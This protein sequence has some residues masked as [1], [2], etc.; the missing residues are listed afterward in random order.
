ME[1]ECCELGSRLEKVLSLQLFSASMEAAA[2]AVRLRSLRDS[3][4]GWGL[5]TMSG[6]IKEGYALHE[7]RSPVTDPWRP[8]YANTDG[9]VFRLAIRLDTAH[10]NGRGMLHGGVIASLADNAMG[11]TLGLAMES[12]GQAELERDKAKGIVTTH[13]GVD[14]IGI[15]ELGQWVEVEPRVVHLGGNSGVTDAIVTADGRTIARAN[16]NFRILR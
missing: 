13:L 3:G 11:L 14:Y 7:R 6:D 15:A 9:N 4:S 16:A 5:T 12:A 10:C 1:A 2:V 8:I